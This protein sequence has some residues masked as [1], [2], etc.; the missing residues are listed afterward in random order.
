MTDAVPPKPDC[1]SAVLLFAEM[2]R[3]RKMLSQ[4]RIK[5]RQFILI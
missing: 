2:L 5:F 4:I 3:S 1:W